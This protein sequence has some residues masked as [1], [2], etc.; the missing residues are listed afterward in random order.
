MDF[1]FCNHNPLNWDNMRLV[2]KLESYLIDG[3]H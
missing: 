1:I 2:V 3:A